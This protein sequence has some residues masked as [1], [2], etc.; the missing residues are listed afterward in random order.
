MGW[1]LI[2]AL[3]CILKRRE[4]QA[5]CRNRP[6]CSY[7]FF[8]NSS[9]SSAVRGT[10]ADRLRQAGF[11]QQERILDPDADVLV[12]LHGRPYLRDERRVLG[13][14]RQVVERALAD[15]DARLDDEGH[16]RLERPSPIADVVHVDADPVR[17]AVRVPERYW[18]PVASVISPSFSSPCLITSTVFWWISARRFP[19]FAALIPSSCA[20]RTRS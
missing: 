18:S 9:I 4:V 19:A 20:C 13:R 3:L 7:R 10:L 2:D 11:G 1:P 17:R 8:M 12:L 5:G 15:V 16:P 14:L 6:V